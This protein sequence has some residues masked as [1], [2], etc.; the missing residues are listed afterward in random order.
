MTEFQNNMTHDYTNFDEPI[1]GDSYH[2]QGPPG[3]QQI[4]AHSHYSPNGSSPSLQTGN[5]RV[6]GNGRYV[7]ASPSS[8]SFFAN[9]P[10]FPAPTTTATSNTTAHLEQLIVNTHLQVKSYFDNIIGSLVDITTRLS[11]LEDKVEELSKRE[12]K[13]RPEPTPQEDSPQSSN[14]HD[15]TSLPQV[16]PV[17]VHNKQMPYG[18]PVVYPTPTSV[19]QQVPSQN[20]NFPPPGPSPYMQMAYRGPPPQQYPM[21]PFMPREGPPFHPSQ[22][23]L[24]VRG[25]FPQSQPPYPSPQPSREPSQQ[26]NQNPNQQSQQYGQQGPSNQ[27][28]QPPVQYAPQAQ[29]AQYPTMPPPNG[30]TNQTPNRV[31]L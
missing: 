7:N 9:L 26:Q 20:H 21:P 16:V 3:L 11:N 31:N 28:Q 12:P 19:Q 5:N 1:K 24:P 18:Q 30:Y 27:F 2:T 14:H 25:P 13:P 8:D 10:D 15:S 23:V 22:M 4:A 17:N 6:V 29:A